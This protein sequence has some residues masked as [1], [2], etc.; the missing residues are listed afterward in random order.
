VRGGSVTAMATPGV[1]AVTADLTDPADAHRAVA[2]SAG[3]PAAPLRAVVNLVGGYAG[4]GQVHETPVEDFERMLT[5]NLRPTYLVTR[6]ALVYLVGV[7]GGAIVCVSSR[8]ALAPFAGAAGYI[9]AKAA[10][11]AFA[12][13]V[14]VEYRGAGVRCNTVVPGVIDT[15][16]NRAARPD[17]NRSS[18]GAPADIARVIRF[19]ASDESAPTTGAAVPV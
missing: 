4:G 2:V 18:W 15:A 3:E 14:A 8:A 16:A 5:L 9:T 13:A 11:L 17:A 19:L 1:T 10:V 12:N 7:G 6:E